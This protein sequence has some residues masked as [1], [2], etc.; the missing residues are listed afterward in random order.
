MKGYCT[1]GEPL[2]QREQMKIEIRQ[3]YELH[4]VEVLM[5]PPILCPPPPLGDNFEIEIRG[6]KIPIRTAI[7]R[8][9]ALAACG[10][11]CGLVLPA[12]LTTLGLPVGVEFDALP[13]KDR[14]LL[15]LGLA[16][17]KALGPIAEPN[18]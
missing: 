5:F 9:T 6:E 2:R 8:N 12:G 15:S 1:F 18:L 7:G 10:S 4:G 17:E 14:A 16:L 11:L 13:N 3:H